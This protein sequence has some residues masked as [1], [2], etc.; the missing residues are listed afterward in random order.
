MKKAILIFI[1]LLI[2]SFA[3]IGQDDVIDELMEDSK[4]E[5]PYRYKMI[6]LNVTPL[7]S[8]L[9]P[10]N[11]TNPLVSGP[12]MMSYRAYR[13]RNAFRFG[14][15]ANLSAETFDNNSASLNMRMGW[16]RKKSFYDNWS[17]SFG[18]D[19]FVSGGS[20][21]LVAN[22][23]NEDGAFG[24]G[25]VWGIEY[26]FNPKVSL[27]IETAFYMGG[28]DDGPVFQF[29]PPVGLNLNFLIPRKSR[30]I[31]DFDE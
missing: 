21:N 14:L 28:G 20:F 9:I 17:Y 3:L 23:N 18:L 7:M 5:F 15:G 24:L 2:F 16:E 31:D 22:G 13:G 26:F 12:Y 11:R 19:F 27:N 29:I 1:S 6:G 8:K 30:N 25:F 10:F 4:F